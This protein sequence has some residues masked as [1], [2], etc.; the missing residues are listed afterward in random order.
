MQ[1]LNKFER[2]LFIQNYGNFWHVFFFEPLLAANNHEIRQELK[3]LGNMLG[4]SLA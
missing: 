3:A 2:S 4:Y 1:G